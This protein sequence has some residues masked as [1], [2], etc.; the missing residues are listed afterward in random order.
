MGFLLGSTTWHTRNHSFN[1]DANF[2]AYHRATLGTLLP[3]DASLDEQG[4]YFS[5]Y[6]QNMV[7]AALF[8]SQTR[9]WPARTQAFDQSRNHYGVSNKYSRSKAWDVPKLYMSGGWRKRSAFQKS[10][11]IVNCGSMKP[12]YCEYDG[13][14]FARANQLCGP[15]DEGWITRN[16]NV[17]HPF[18]QRKLHFLQ[19]YKSLLEVARAQQPR[20]CFV[21]D[22]SFDP[23]PAR[24]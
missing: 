23:I 24:I 1:I 15:V 5:Q 17:S 19:Q 13:T 3:Y 7:R 12:D 4:I 11:D 2:N 14:S 18:V 21:D 20:G 6:I 10:F 16:M 8:A 9:Y 22:L